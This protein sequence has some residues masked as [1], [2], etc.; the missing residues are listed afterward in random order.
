MTSSPMTSPHVVGQ[1]DKVDLTEAIDCTRVVLEAY[2]AAVAQL[3]SE[4]SAFEAA[5]RVYHQHNPKAS[6]ATARRE[7]ATII[8]NKE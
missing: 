4:R 3:Q 2:T 8:S 1:P 5:V 7:V 6:E